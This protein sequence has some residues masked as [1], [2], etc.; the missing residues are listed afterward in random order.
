MKV[1]LVFRLGVFSLS[2]FLCTCLEKMNAVKHD[3]SKVHNYL[4]WTKNRGV[5][6]LSHESVCMFVC[7]LII[8][9]GIF[10]FVVKLTCH[11]AVL[12]WGL[13]MG[14]LQCKVGYYALYEY[15]YLVSFILVTW[16]TPASSARRL[17]C[18]GR[19]CFFPPSAQHKLGK[20]STLEL[21][22]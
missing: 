17:R 7:G 8:I 6:S 13:K 3:I 22:F 12:Y 19:Q 20:Q 18:G 21:H 16:E 9:N 1:M 5:I 11:S 2:L 14:P 15:D 10:N 4:T